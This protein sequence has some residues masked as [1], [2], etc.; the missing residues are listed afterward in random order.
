MPTIHVYTNPRGEE[1]K[2]IKPNRVNWIME[3]LSDGRRVK[4]DARLYTFLETRDIDPEPPVNPLIRI[5]AIV[6][7]LPDAPPVKAGRARPGDTYVIIGFGLA[8]NEF[9]I[10]EAGGNPGN[11][12]YKSVHAKHLSL[13]E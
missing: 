3:H 13:G 7:L 1:L 4:G 2:L 5:G 6:D 11:S 10:I 12:Y 8:P 9:K